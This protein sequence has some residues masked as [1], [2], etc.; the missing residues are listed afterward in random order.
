LNIVPATT[1]SAL[2]LQINAGGVQATNYQSS[3]TYAG[4]GSVS[5]ITLATAAQLSISQTS[6]AAYGGVSGFVRIAAPSNSTTYKPIFG[7][8]SCNNG[9]NQYVCNFSS[10]WTNA[11][12]AVTGFQFLFSAGNITSGTVK[13]YGII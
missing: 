6:T 3:I 7:S 1:A 8:A 5:A 11:T 10:M 13:V 9:T 12:T 2:Y 4:A